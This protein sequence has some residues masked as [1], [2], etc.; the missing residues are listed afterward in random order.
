MQNKQLSEWI[1]ATL[2]QAAWA[3]LCI[4]GI[5]AIGL[6][7]HL[8]DRYPWLDIPTHFLGGMAITYFYRTAI[9][10]SHTLLGPTP[11]LMQILFAFTATGTTTVF[12]EFYENFIDHFFG[13]RTVR[14]LGETIMDLAM[15]LSGALVLTLFYRKK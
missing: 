8:Y 5:Y 1:W 13:F 11:N 14:G 4:V 9:W 6:T 7:F 2:R 12:W 10:N 15:G 3:P